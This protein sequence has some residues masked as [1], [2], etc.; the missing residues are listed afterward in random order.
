MDILLCNSYYLCYEKIPGAS[1]QPYA[2]L[3]ILYLA[4]Y[5]K[6][7]GE[8]Q[9]EMF[10]TTF[11]DGVP[12]FESTL[13]RLKPRVVG[14]QG[15]ITTRRIAKQ[16]IQIAK[17]NNAVVVVG[18]PDPSS[19]WGDYIGWGADYVVIGEGELALHKLL[20]NLTA[21]SSSATLED[22]AGLA[23]IRNGQIH[24]TAPCEKIANLDCIPFPAYHLIDVE[25]YLC[26]WRNYNGY[27]SMH[28]LT[29]RGCPFSCEW[30]SHAVFERTFRQRSIENVIAEMR[31]LK[32]HYNPDHLTIG[33][34]TFGLNKKWLFRWCNAVKEEDFNFVF[35]CF[36]RVDVVDEEMLRR[37]KMAGCSHIHLGVESGSQRILDCMNKGTKIEDIYRASRLIKDCGIGLGYFIMFAYPGETYEDIHKTE[38]LIF[39]IKPDTLGL[40]IAF[41]VPGTHFFERVKDNILPLDNHDE[42]Q[43]GSG[44]QLRFNAS[45]PVLYYRRLISYIE[46]RSNSYSKQ[47]SFIQRIVATIKIIADYVFLRTFER[48][49]PLF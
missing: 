8:F 36:S 39:E 3:G 32:E 45:Y 43:L 19:S 34:D 25:R 20:S 35:R 14:I 47:K 30:C 26:E 17:K 11:A 15:L 18:G 5:L 37:L 12:A 6:Q 29:S 46:R 4:A 16:M 23:Y 28:L 13:Q 21:R 7:F 49:W 22:I 1:G 40:S 38:R 9:V 44:H 2:P 41:P 27:A 48:L 10:D 31:F 33:D 42:E 24:R